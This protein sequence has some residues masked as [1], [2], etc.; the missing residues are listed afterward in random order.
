MIRDGEFDKRAML[1][2]NG[3]ASCRRQ[4]LK[5]ETL[6]E[7]KKESERTEKRVISTRGSRDKLAR[8]SVGFRENNPSTYLLRGTFSAREARETIE[9]SSAALANYNSPYSSHCS[10]G[11][12]FPPPNTR[13]IQSAK[14]EQ[15][16]IYIS[17]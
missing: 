16:A 10:A 2:G 15:R 13:E 8:R 9:L 6:R 5:I 3:I 14:R 11:R 1:D 17:A 12:S 4:R 7:R